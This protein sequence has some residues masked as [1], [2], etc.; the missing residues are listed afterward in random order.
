MIRK[1]LGILILLMALL[2]L[3][4]GFYAP[5]HAQI[6]RTYLGSI[7]SIRDLSQGSFRHDPQNF[8]VSTANILSSWLAWNN[9]EIAKYL[10]ITITGCTNQVDCYARCEELF[11]A[12]ATTTTLDAL[13]PTFPGQGT[14]IASGSSTLFPLTEHMAQCYA[15]HTAAQN[16]ITPGT[17]KIQIASVGTR[18]N[19]D[20]FCATG[21]DG[22]Q[23]EDLHNASDEIIPQQFRDH[24]CSDETIDDIVRFTVVR[25]ALTIMVNQQNPLA[26]VELDDRQLR[27]LLAYADQWSEVDPLGT[28]QFIARYYPSSDS[29]TRSFLV[30]RLFQ[31]TG[32]SGTELLDEAHFVRPHENDRWAAQQIARNPAAMGFFGYR[33][34]REEQRSLHALA[35]N[36]IAPDEIDQYPLTRPLYL[37]TTKEKLAANPLLRDFLAYYLAR[38]NGY[39]G[40]LGYFPLHEENYTTTVADF[41]TTMQE[42]GYVP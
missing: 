38:V 21:A 23:S 11:T 34:Y 9:E 10:P 17:F 26:A 30:D 15:Y 28:S 35:I 36:G 41:H 32:I 27:F 13:Q 22:E 40:N 16:A 29:G 42:L 5:L 37:Y 24:G 3:S 12:E 20:R 14:I 8:A 19:L 25:D 31:D 33:F 18:G 4:V 2:V 6:Y 39:A 1:S 7:D